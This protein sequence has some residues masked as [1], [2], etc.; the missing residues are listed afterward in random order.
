MPKKQTLKEDIIIRSIKIVDIAF[1]TCLYVIPT[2]YVAK[3]FDHYV[4][5]NITPYKHIPENDKTQAQLIAELLIYL[6]I[7]G[8]LAYVLR[9]I[10]Q[11]IPFPLEGV[12]G[13]EHMR[14][15]E[16]S[17]GQLIG[18][19]LIWFS[20][21]IRDKMILLQSKLNENFKK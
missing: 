16:V 17:S 6:S 10:L 7:N 4:Y 9:N 11:L 15:K 2:L 12:Y 19:I 3:T 5:P 1:I 20:K 14:V 18:F 13:F 21:V 8:V